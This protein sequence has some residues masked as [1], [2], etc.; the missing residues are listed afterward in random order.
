MAE[1]LKRH[2]HTHASRRLAC[3]GLHPYP[4]GPRGPVL[5]R[6]R[7]GGLLC[8]GRADPHRCRGSGHRQGPDPF[9]RG[10]PAGLHHPAIRARSLW[11][12]AGGLGDL[13]HPRVHPR[14]LPPAGQAR[15]CRHRPG[16][17]LPGRRSGAAHRLRP[18]H[19]HRGQGG[20]SA[21]PGGRGRDPGM[22]GQAGVRRQGPLRHHRLLLGRLGGV[23]VGGA[24]PADQGR[25]GLVWPAEGLQ[26]R[27]GRTAR[28]RAAL[29]H[30][31]G[32]GPEGAGGRPLRRAG[33]GHH[34]GRRPGHAR[35]AGGQSQGR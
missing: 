30:R 9:R 4:S 11:R 27:P 24:V 35:G 13:W 16:L 21:D 14:H 18:D 12:R 15:L 28:R 23:D 2:G 31:R 22:A 26:A 34:P 25:R 10:E 5:R 3:S 8:R 32:Q 17:L 33:P 29:A 6:L 1:G 19:A 7:H 20:S